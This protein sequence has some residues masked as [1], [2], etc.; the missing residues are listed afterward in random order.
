MVGEGR[1]HSRGLLKEVVV[2][3]VEGRGGEGKGGEG[4]ILP[5]QAAGCSRGG[6]QGQ[7]L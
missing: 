4:M 6:V 1:C 2:L 3:M 5:A 7:G